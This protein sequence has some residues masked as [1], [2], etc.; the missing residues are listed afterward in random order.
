MAGKVKHASPTC[1]Q[2]RV[3]IAGMDTLVLPCHDVNVDA[4]MF[5]HLKSNLKGFVQ[6]RKLIPGEFMPEFNGPTS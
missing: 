2:A 5:D 4:G 3:P 6:F 1:H